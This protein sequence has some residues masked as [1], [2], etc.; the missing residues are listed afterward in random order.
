MGA[1][2]KRHS[3]GKSRYFA[4]R[5]LSEPLTK[6][7]LRLPSS[8]KEMESLPIVKTNRS[9]C[10]LCGFPPFHLRIY[11]YLHREQQ[12]DLVPLKSKVVFCRDESVS[13]KLALLMGPQPAQRRINDLKHRVSRCFIALSKTFLGCCRYL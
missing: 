7:S 5:C 6:E 11:Q 2:C 10:I 3:P 13:W 4:A 8:P 1:N 12:L 9:F